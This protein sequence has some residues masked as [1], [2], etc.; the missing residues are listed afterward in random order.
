MP[1]CRQNCTE[2]LD[3]AATVVAEEEVLPFDHPPR[4]KLAQHDTIEEF[5]GG[6]AQQRRIGRIS[7]DG[8]DSQ[9]VQQPRL[10]LGPA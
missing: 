4:T 2:D 1:A 9:F 3:V 5:T 10:V 8:I 6:E 7:H